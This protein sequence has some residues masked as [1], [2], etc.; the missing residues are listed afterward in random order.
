M[1]QEIHV[2][3]VSHGHGEHLELLLNDLAQQN[4]AQNLQLSLVHN[5]A[6]QTPKA[7]DSLD[8]PYSVIEN[9]T[10]KGFAAN[11]NLAFH[12]PPEPDSARYFLVLNPDVRLNRSALQDLLQAMTDAA[13]Q[14]LAVL[15]PTVF[16]EHGVQQS[17]G[18][19]FP[20]LRYLLKKL[21][22]SEPENPIDMRN[23]L[24]HVD[25][26]AG[27]CMLINRDHFQAIGGFDEHYRLY[28][29]DVDLCLRLCQAGFYNAITDQSQIIH[30]GQWQS[31]RNFTHLRW[32]ISSIWRFLGKMRRYKQTMNKA[33]RTP[34]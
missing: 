33:A 6:E 12:Q 25:W 29:E 18:R 31:R 20:N 27:M 1:S 11:H 17:T 5:I 19:I 28:Y 7:L 9:K 23:G 21:L 13:D 32:H 3:I 14:Q 26:V 22:G 30:Q 15:G 2:S 24:A 34:S 16:D 4:I 10:P 8:F